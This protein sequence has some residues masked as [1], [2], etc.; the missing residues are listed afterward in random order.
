V[1]PIKKEKIGTNMVS[2]IFIQKTS[3]DY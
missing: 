2:W 3:A 1:V